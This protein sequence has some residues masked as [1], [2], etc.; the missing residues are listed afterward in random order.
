MRSSALRPGWAGGAVRDQSRTIAE[1]VVAQGLD[2]SAVARHRVDHL[3]AGRSGQLAMEF[4]ATVR[5]LGGAG[6]RAPLSEVVFDDTWGN[7]WIGA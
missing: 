4:K 2:E 5:A 3:V 6:R 7:G 1:T